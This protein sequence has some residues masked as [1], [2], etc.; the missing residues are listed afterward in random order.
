LIAIVI[1]PFGF[2][3]VGDFTVGVDTVTSDG[4]RCIRLWG[5]TNGLAQLVNEGPTAKT[6]LDPAAPLEI[7]R[8]ACQVRPANPAVWEK[9]LSPP[10]WVEESRVS[11]AKTTTERRDDA[12]A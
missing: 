3:Y 2:I 12:T 4:A 8:L 9:H 6:V 11:K 7:H 1:A 10:A 5:S